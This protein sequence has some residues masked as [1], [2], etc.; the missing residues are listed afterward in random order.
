MTYEDVFRYYLI[1][2]RDLLNKSSRAL[3]TDCYNEAFDRPIV[4]EPYSVYLLEYDKKHIELAR[5][6]NPHLT[7]IQGDIRD[8]PFKDKYF[9][10]VLDLSTIDHV[11]PQD[12]AKVIAEYKR[13]CTKTL[14]IVTWFGEEI[15]E[16]PWEPT[17]QYF[18]DKDWFLSQL[19][20]DFTVA[21]LFTDR[22]INKEL[23]EIVCS[24]PQT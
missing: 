4:A 23:W 10:L 6:K 5:E 9:D 13:V 15:E 22:T 3:K 21:H 14:Y 12:V 19:D 17:D 7:I 2:S 18:F 24:I 11:P 16:K 1:K 8:L 20:M